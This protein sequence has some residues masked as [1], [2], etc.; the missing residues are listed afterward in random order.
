MT[1]RPG[2]NEESEHQHDY[3]AHRTVEHGSHKGPFASF[4]VFFCESLCEN[5]DVTFVCC[6]HDYVQ[7]AQASP[8]HSIHITP[9]FDSP[10]GKGRRNCVGWRP[11]FSNFGLSF[12][13]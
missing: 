1:S 5:P 3:T 7:S 12:S 4:I 2:P 9:L 6:A 13:V 10:L 8:S 11:W